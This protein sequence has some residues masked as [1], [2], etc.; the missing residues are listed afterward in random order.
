MAPTPGQKNLTDVQMYALQAELAHRHEVRGGE[1]VLSND[2]MEDIAKKFG[3]KARMIR[4]CWSRAKKHCNDHG[5]WNFPFGKKNNKR[6]QL[7]DRA[8]LQSALEAVPHEAR[9][10]HRDAASELGV[11]K[12]TFQAIMKEKVVV[13]HTAAMKPVLND[14]HRVLRVNCCAE[15]LVRKEDGKWCCKL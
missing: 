9:G 12:S 7:H 2:R 10:A 3:V 4:H 5:N 1:V 14:Q 13:P 11:A 6:P 8:E 15:R